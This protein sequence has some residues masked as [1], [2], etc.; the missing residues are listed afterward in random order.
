MTLKQPWHEAEVPCSSIH[1]CDASSF[2]K[3]HEA[4]SK[5]SAQSFFHV[6]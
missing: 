3:L 6:V 4:S 1:Q 5:A 2:M